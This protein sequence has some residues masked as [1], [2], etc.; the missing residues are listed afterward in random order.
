MNEIK[1]DNNQCKHATIIA[2]CN[3]MVHT[4]QRMREISKDGKWKL[5]DAYIDSAILSSKLL[6]GDVTEAEREF[7]T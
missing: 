7:K 2:Q 1:Y 3:C 4:L 6:L 5:L